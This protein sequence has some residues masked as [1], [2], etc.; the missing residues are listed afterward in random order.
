MFPTHNGVVTTSESFALNLCITLP[1]T[2]KELTMSVPD[3]VVEDIYQELKYIF[4]LL[5]VF[6]DELIPTSKIITFLPVPPLG[7]EKILY[8]SIKAITLFRIFILI[9]ISVFS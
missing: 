1:F 4:S 2:K 9:K 8:F 3:Y 6:A 7:C 5:S